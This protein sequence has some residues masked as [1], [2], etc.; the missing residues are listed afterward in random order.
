[1]GPRRGGPLDLARPGREGSAAHL[2]LGTP[3]RPSP[4]MR[5]SPALLAGRAPPKE[6][7]LGSAPFPCRHPSGGSHLGPEPGIG[8]D[9]SNKH[10]DHFRIKLSSRTRLKPA[11]RFGPG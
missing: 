10:I 5:P 7:P 4:S 2:A 9:V 1:P 8:G 11:D 6:P 3:P